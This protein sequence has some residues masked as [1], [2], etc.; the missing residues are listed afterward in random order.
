MAENPV[1]SPSKPPN[2]D[3]VAAIATRQDQPRA[4]GWRGRLSVRRRPLLEL[5]DPY[6]EADEVLGKFAARAHLHQFFHTCSVSPSLS[7]CYLLRASSGYGV[8]IVH[9]NSLS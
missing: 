9:G 5:G 1:P 3:T 7:L 8:K 6:F 2:A 4:C